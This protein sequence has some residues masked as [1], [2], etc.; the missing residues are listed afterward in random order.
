MKRVE[1][2]LPG[3]HVAQRDLEVVGVGR[4]DI[5]IRVP[6]LSDR[7]SEAYRNCNRAP[8]ASGP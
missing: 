5:D 4:A 8:F 7:L 3:T 2:R 6:D 1:R